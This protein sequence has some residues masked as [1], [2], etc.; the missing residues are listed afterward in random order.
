MNLNINVAQLKA[1]FPMVRYAR[2]C[3]GVSNHIRGL[4]ANGQSPENIV[5]YPPHIEMAIYLHP[6]QKPSSL[7]LA[8]A[9]AESAGPRQDDATTPF[10]GEVLVKSDELSVNAAIWRGHG[11]TRNLNKINFDDPNRL[12][13]AAADLLRFIV[14]GTIPEQLFHS[15]I[16]QELGLRMKH[17][18]FCGNWLGR[19]LSGAPVE[20]FSVPDSESEIEVA[21]STRLLVTLD[22]MAETFRR[23]AI[24]E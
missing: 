10:W 4:Q 21:E 5:N 1:A 13:V 16:E 20:F 18:N 14:D 19:E 15:V 22:E 3:I 24:E 17:H 11:E 12:F 23:M 9:V 2:R 6:E 8:F 7:R